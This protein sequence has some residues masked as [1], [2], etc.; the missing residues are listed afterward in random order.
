MMLRPFEGDRLATQIEK[1]DELEFVLHYAID[2][3]D[4]DQDDAGKPNPAIVEELRHTNAASIDIFRLII[5]DAIVDKMCRDTVT[6]AMQKG[7][8]IQ[9]SYDDIY[10]YIAVLLLSGYCKVP[11]RVIKPAISSGKHKHKSLTVH[12]KLKV[13]ET[14]QNGANVAC[15]CAEYGIVKQTVSDIQKKKAELLSFVIKCDVSEE[16]CQVKRM[17]QPAE[18]K[19]ED[20]V[21]KWYEQFRASDIA[22][23]LKFKLLLYALRSNLLSMDFRL[24]Q[25]GYTESASVKTS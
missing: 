2:G 14:L 25:A 8:Q 20:A 9:V 1:A 22:G 21:Y 4:S 23:V 11:H 10:K 12:E 15:V 16:S 24:V 17:W 6:Y 3:T 19:L 5:D 13:I 18:R 7:T